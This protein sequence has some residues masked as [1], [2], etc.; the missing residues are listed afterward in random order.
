MCVGATGACALEEAS[1]RTDRPA[2]APRARPRSRP[3]PGT[4][5][6]ARRACAPPPHPCA[7]MA[8]PTS[9]PVR[10]ATSRAGIT[11][12]PRYSPITP[13]SL[14]SP[15]PMPAGWASARARNAANAP[16]PATRYSGRPGRSTTAHAPHAVDGRHEHDRVRDHPALQ[17]DHREDDQRRGERERQGELGL[18]PTHGDHGAERDRGAQLEQGVARRDPGATA[19]AAP[20]QDHPREHRD[21][22]APAQRAPAVRAGRPRR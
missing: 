21:V 7:I 1:R 22:V 11:D 8:R 6:T 15:M 20:T 14:T 9:D 4:A 12:T 13:A 17:V 2:R 18:H 3:E 19:G 5:R 16:A 10:K